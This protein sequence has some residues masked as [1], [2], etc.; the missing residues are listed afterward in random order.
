L[1]ISNA[2]AGKTLTIST[3]GITANSAGAKTITNKGSSTGGV[4][5]SGVIGNGSGTVAVVQN[6]GTSVL[7]LSGANTFT[8]GLSILQG[9]ATVGNS[10]GAGS[11][12]ISIGGG[13]ANATLATSGAV[14]ITNN[15]TVQSGAGTTTIAAGGSGAYIITGTTTLMNGQSLAVTGGGATKSGYTQKI[16]ESGGSSAVNFTLTSNNTSQQFSFGNSASDYTGGTVITS[17]SSSGNSQA[18]SFGGTSASTGGGSGTFLGK[19]SVTFKGTTAGVPL[20]LQQVGG[21][22]TITNISS[23]VFDMDVATRGLAVTF[24]SATVDLGDVSVSDTTR[25][26]GVGSTAGNLTFSGVIQ[27]GSNGITKNVEIGTVAG[28]SGGTV[29]LGGV[30]TYTGSTTVS[31]GTLQ[32]STGNDRLPTGT[33]LSV[34]AGTS[35]GVAGGRVDLNSRNQTV[36]G[37][38][39]GSGSGGQGIIA[40]TST[41]TSTLT[42]ANTSASQF[43]GLL[44]DSASTRKLALIKSSG[45]T[46]TLTGSN[47][48]SGGTT[49]GG[50][51]LVVTGTETS[52]SGASLTGSAVSG[53]FAITG[54]ASTSGL[55]VGQQISGTNIASGSYITSIV[56]SSSVTISQVTTGAIASGSLTFGA[57]NGSG[58]GNGSVA[59]N[60]GG[61]LLVNGTLGA[62]SA[63][64]VN[65]GGV[66]GGSGTIKGNTTISSGGT[67]APG[68]SP[69]VLT[70]NG[71]LTLAGT[72]A[73]QLDGLTRGSLY[74]GINTGAGLL[75]LGGDLTLNFG[76]ATS[77]LAVYDLFNI[78]A[79]SLAGSFANV[80]LA[81]LYSGSLTNSSGVWTG[82]NGGFSF[83]FDQA[84]GDLSVIAV[85]EPSTF[86]LFGLGLGSLWLLRKK[87]NPLAK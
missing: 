50:G 13:S 16:T 8:G 85:P 49:V 62:S 67:L 66:L 4:T 74:D 6:S 40:N 41:T 64:T 65:S 46:L 47:N 27:D 78:G 18:L 83:S 19:G 15:I 82:T 35:A 39:G 81:G 53:A 84:T 80:T 26:F 59:V 57:Y 12:T 38:T 7:T 58:L 61:T 87:R 23:L 36:A 69:G 31:A 71:T 21:A 42:V 24:N 1:D 54:L 9:Q 17:A 11:G 44:L 2:A 51:T 10:T 30:S 75:T 70:F 3:G 14:N 28:F 22:A 34:N 25:K 37:L 60:S 72:T 48:Y 68:N 55:V 77:D 56:S 73:M 32:L 43:D 63:V 76:A 79:G 86:V 33:T 29:V 52:A 45:G 20:L 5:I